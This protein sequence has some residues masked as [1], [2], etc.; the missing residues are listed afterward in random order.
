MSEEDRR[1]PVGSVAEEATKLLHA[2]QG[3]AEESG[4]QYAEA[5][6]S[7]AAGAAGRLK[8]VDEHIATG[9]DSCTYCP[10]CQL[11]AAVRGTSPEVRQHLTSAATSMMQAVAAL[12]ATPVP[13]RSGG[14]PE[15]SVEKID[16]SD[17][18]LDDELEDD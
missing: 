13:D 3:W 16:L 7:V 9:A 10:L 4:G 11:V 1:P 18:E 8:D 6:A 2:L 12:M 17:D 15:S 14:R 5:A